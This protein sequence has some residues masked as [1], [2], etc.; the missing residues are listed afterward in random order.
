MQAPARDGAP[1]ARFGE[2]VWVEIVVPAAVAKPKDFFES[3]EAIPPSP[4]GLLP[5]DS[6]TELVA[7]FQGLGAEE[8]EILLPNLPQIAALAVILRAHAAQ[9]ALSPGDP[10]LTERTLEQLLALEQRAAGR[11]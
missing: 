2:R 8:L 11:E 9:L 1:A 7:A 5:V 4:T 6:L 3:L 10:G